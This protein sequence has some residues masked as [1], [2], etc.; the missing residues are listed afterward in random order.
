M[1][2]ITWDE[3]YAGEDSLS[4]TPS[5]F[6]A[7]QISRLSGGKALDLAMGS[8]RNSIFLA[9]NGYEVDAID[10][11]S[12]AVQ[13]LQSYVKDQSLSIAVKKADL[14]TYQIPDATYD[15]IINFNYLE[16]SLIPQIKKGL[17][18]GGMLL[19]ETYTIEQPRYGRPRN[20]D[21]LLKPNELL[22][23]FSDLHII[24]YHERVDHSGEQPQ[25]IASL[26]AQKV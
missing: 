1:T 5:L 19:F 20:P 17:S 9:M 16:R 3:K 11:S 13:K 8:G 23:S 18:Q 21:Y 22:S 10:Y 4:N 25:A 26:L 2:D 12:V 24:F 6:L 15:L 7:Q 14:T